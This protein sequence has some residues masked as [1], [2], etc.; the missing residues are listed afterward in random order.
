MP[1]SIYEGARDMARQ[2]APIVGGAHRATAASKVEM[3]QGWSIEAARGALRSASDPNLLRR[4]F[5]TVLRRCIREGLVGGEDF[6]I[7]ASLIKADANRQ[8]GNAGERV[9][10]RKPQG[11][12]S[13]SIWLCSTTRLSA[14]R[15]T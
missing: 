15:P 12:L 14:P 9:C 11:A 8:N 7:D 6:A 10:L 4:V 1:R 5:E 2:I 3:R 13:R